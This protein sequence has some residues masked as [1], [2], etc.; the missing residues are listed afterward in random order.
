MSSDP[1]LPAKM[2]VKAACFGSTAI[3]QPS[4]LIDD[5]VAAFPA[6]ATPKP[7]PGTIADTQAHVGDSAPPSGHVFVYLDRDY[8]EILPGSHVLVRD[9]VNEGHSEVHGVET[10]SV[11]AYGLSAK[12][13]RLEL[14]A[15][16]AGPASAVQ[17]SSFTTRK[18]TIYAAPQDLPRANLP[19]TSVVGAS[20]GALGADEVEIA[21][22]E[23]ALFPGKTLVL[24]GERAD[25]AGVFASEIL[26]LADNT[27][28]DGFSVLKFTQAPAH[29]Y[30]R[31]SV[32]INANVAEA[33][34]GETV[35][36][37]LGDGDAA[38]PFAA[39]ALT[40]KPLTHVSAKTPSGMAPSIE[41]RVAGVLWERVGGFHDA[42]P[43]DRVYVVRMEEDG[44]AKVVF[45]DGEK[46]QRPPTG[47][48][49]IVAVYRKGAGGSGML[50]AGQLSLLATKP[51]GLKAVVNSLPPAAAADGERIE[52]A[53]RNAPLPVLTLG[54]VVSLR[55][56]EDFARGFAAIAKARADW[57]FDGFRRRRRRRAAAPGRRRRTSSSISKPPARTSPLARTRGW[58]IP[59]WVASIPRRA[60]RPHGGSGWSRSR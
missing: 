56:Y 21:T 32:T 9:A 36:E 26:T 50:E 60:S 57:T 45:G 15:A 42:G 37:T 59:R 30:F 14:N 41:V 31:H 25:F 22:A 54:Q 8:P 3:T 49:N 16:L 10:L 24:S 6:A 58:P 1:I 12:V 17:A 55:D 5:I 2:Q 40:G 4:P 11:E 48:D 23:L 27:L 43:E 46:G 44:S 51:A 35:S 29:T 38:R 53:R 13:T 18:T 7:A 33:T 20:S 39:Y 34:H 19:I 52:D 28:N 47:Q